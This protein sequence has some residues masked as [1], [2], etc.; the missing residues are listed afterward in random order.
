MILKTPR[1]NPSA[2]NGLKIW[3]NGSKCTERNNFP[4]NTSQIETYFDNQNR[5]MN[6]Y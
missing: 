4:Y 2:G 3:V 1:R 6:V 5:D